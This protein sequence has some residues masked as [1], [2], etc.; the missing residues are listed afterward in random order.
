MYHDEREL[1][2]PVVELLEEEAPLLKRLVEGVEARP[3]IAAYMKSD[4]CV[5]SVT[6]QP[7]E[8]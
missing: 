8:R 1:G 5:E 7:C 6:D 2:G 4:R 3:R